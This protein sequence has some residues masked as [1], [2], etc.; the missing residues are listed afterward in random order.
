VFTV[1]FEVIYCIYI[2][3]YIYTHTQTM[4]M[5]VAIAKKSIEICVIL[6]G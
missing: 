3:I 4:Y 2:Y 6:Q 1:S 5:C